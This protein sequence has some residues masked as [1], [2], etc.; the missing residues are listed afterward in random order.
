MQ[1]TPAEALLLLDPDAIGGAQAVKLTLTGLLLQSV[2][3]IEKTR[4]KRRFFFGSRAATVI[5]RVR[6][7]PVPTPPHVA[8]VMDHV[9]RARDGEMKRFMESLARATG[10]FAR[11]MP[12]FVVPRLVQ[13]GL[14]EVRT[15]KREVELPGGHIQPFTEERRVL[16]ATGAAAA[17]ELRQRLDEAQGLKT[18][19]D[20]D[21]QRAAAMAAALGGL[22]VLVPG[23][24]AF[25]PDIAQAIGRVQAW[26]GT[27]AMVGGVGGFDAVGGDRRASEDMWREVETGAPDGLDSSLADVDAAFGSDGGG[28]WDSGGGGDS[29]ASSSDSGSSDGGEP[30]R[31]AE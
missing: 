17:A 28:D 10:R 27:D 30:D 11:F 26:P 12:D 23:V 5:R 24:L 2:L 4:I 14:M 15:E 7:A 18:M 3:R 16:T 13:R 20:A 29:G 21:P 19:L 9:E 25:L 31:R 8:L 22:L 1:Q 6:P